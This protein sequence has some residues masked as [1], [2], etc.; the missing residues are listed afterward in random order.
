MT[1]D[2]CKAAVDPRFPRDMQSCTWK[3]TESSFCDDYDECKDQAEGDCIGKTACKWTT[4]DDNSG[5]GDGMTGY[6]EYK[7]Y[8]ERAEDATSCWELQDETKCNTGTD[9]SKDCMLVK[10]VQSSC[11]DYDL[12]TT[13]KSEEDCGGLKGCAWQIDYMSTGMGDDQ[14]EDAKVCTRSFG[15][16]GGGGND[17]MDGTDGIATGGMEGCWSKSKEADCK[18]MKDDAGDASCAWVKIDY[19]TGSDTV[20]SHPT[21]PALVIASRTDYAARTGFAKSP[22]SGAQPIRLE[23]YTKPAA[24]SV[25]ESVPLNIVC[26]LQK[27]PLL[28]SHSSGWTHTVFPK[29]HTACTRASVCTGAHVHMMR[30]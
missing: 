27:C 25:C 29:A 16:V 15:D 13:K 23:Q 2:K 30:T 3:V 5:T 10:N 21:Q 12:C 14:D 22:V 19:E 1:E 17:G 28:L 18:G 24:L 20:S 11:M 4:F 8:K 7:E 26:M 9:R 6:C